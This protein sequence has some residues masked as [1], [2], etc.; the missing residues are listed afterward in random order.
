[1]SSGHVSVEADGA[2]EAAENTSGVDEWPDKDGGTETDGVVAVELELDD[3]TLY[4]ITEPELE[5]G[6]RFDPSHDGSYIGGRSSSSTAPASLS[7]R[8]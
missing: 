3:A 5:P 8:T 1:M 7:C 6:P 4:P 2:V